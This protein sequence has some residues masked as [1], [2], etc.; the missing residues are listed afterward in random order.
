MPGITEFH[1][2][3]GLKPEGKEGYEGLFEKREQLVDA[4]LTLEQLRESITQ[5]RK[6][7]G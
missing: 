6:E 4:E 1:L 7:R 5:A 2:M 3:G